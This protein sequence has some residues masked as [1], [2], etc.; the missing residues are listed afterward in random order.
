MFLAAGCSSMNGP[1]YEHVY[2][3]LNTGVK[4]TSFLSSGEM[5]IVEDMVKARSKAGDGS[6][7]PLRLSK[8]LSFAARQK[9]VEVADKGQKENTPKPQ[10]FMSR[11]QR[12][13]KVKGSFAEL[14]SHGYPQRI[15][16]EQLMKQENT[17]EGEKLELYFLNPEYTVAGVGCA[18]DL[19]PICAIAFATDF[20]EP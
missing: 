20:K 11:V 7:K 16:V 12:F 4:D 19:Y 5:E 8:G 6:L 3:P 14:V 13:G 9:A 17:P 2:V 18:G 1:G 15:V 10:P